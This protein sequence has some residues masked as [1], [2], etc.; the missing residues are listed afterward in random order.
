MI[1]GANLLNAALRIIQKQNFTYYANTGRTT[2]SIGLDVAVY[3]AGIP[4]SG[5]V[6]PVPRN[7]YANMGLDFQKNYYNFFLQNNIIDIDRD[8]SGDQFVYNS[9]R[10]QCLSKTNW[11][12]V[13]GWDQV[14]CVQVPN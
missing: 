13:E 2:N 3:A 6:Q 14:L 12:A 8:V 9:A 1:P 5:S 7:L 4:A 10:F 11:F